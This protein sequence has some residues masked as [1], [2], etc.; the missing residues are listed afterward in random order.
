MGTIENAKEIADLAKKIGDADL[1]RKI[2]EREGEVI[3]LTRDKRTPENHNEDLK[4]KLAIV[5][6]MTF[7]ELF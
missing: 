1:Y 4:E 7:R 3:D 5:P 2:V 6:E